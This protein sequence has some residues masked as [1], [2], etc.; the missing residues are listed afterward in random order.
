[1]HTLTHTPFSLSL[2]VSLPSFS[3][4][5]EREVAL[6]RERNSLYI[7]RARNRYILKSLSLLFTSLGNDFGKHFR[8]AL[9]NQS[10]ARFSHKKA[11][12]IVTVME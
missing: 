10:R 4:L 8:G 3:P 2:S 1:M 5:P 12:Y 7:D 6:E 11:F 9:I